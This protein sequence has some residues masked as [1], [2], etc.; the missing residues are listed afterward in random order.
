MSAKNEITGGILYIVS[1]PIGNLDDMTFR[2]ISVLKRLMTILTK[3]KASS[4][5]NYSTIARK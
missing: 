5:R 4:N 2:G 3:V 1:T